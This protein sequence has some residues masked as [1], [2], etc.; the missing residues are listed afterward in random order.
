M[1]KKLSVSCGHHPEHR[2]GSTDNGGS[3]P[4]GAEM[5]DPMVKK[6]LNALVHVCAQL[7]AAQCRHDL[8]RKPSHPTSDTNAASSGPI[9][10]S[11]ASFGSELEEAPSATV[12]LPRASFNLAMSSLNDGCGHDCRDEICPSTCLATAPPSAPHPQCR[13]LNNHAN[14]TAPHT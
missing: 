8:S 12:G 11:H 13:P 3:W 10:Q 14:P 5:S 1:S 6:K 7:L 9:V 4:E 2:P